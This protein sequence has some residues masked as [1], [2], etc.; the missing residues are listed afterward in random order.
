MDGCLF[1]VFM[2][3]FTSARFL[4]ELS[5]VHFGTQ[6]GG[7]HRGELTPFGTTTATDDSHWCAK[8]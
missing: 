1:R 5:I 3:A 2:D 4:V 8:L 6:R 7:H